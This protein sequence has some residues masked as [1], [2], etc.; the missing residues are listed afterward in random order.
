VWQILL[1]I[2]FL[3]T[4]PAH[5]TYDSVYT[6][7]ALMDPKEMKTK[8]TKLKIAEKYSFTR[9][10]R[11]E[12]AHVVNTFSGVSSILRDGAAFRA[13]YVERAKEVIPG[14]G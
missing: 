3:R 10:D 11:S 7:F 1:L 5:Y 4:L 14:R 8:L 12:H 6:W 13:S 2:V 9:P